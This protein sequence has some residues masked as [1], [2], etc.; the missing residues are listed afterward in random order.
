MGKSS[1]KHCS[2]ILQGFK[3]QYLVLRTEKE[4][5]YPAPFKPAYSFIRVMKWWGILDFEGPS[6]CFMGKYR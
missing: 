2:T 5:K 3:G 4:F 1:K 6:A